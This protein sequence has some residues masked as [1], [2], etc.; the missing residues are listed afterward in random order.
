MP[1]IDYQCSQCGY[2]FEHF[3]HSDPPNSQICP[4]LLED[5]R[6]C[7]SASLRI[8]SLPGEYRPTNAQRF[9]PI[10]IWV[11]NDNPDQVS[12]PGRADEPVQA[13]YHPVEITSI[14]E[15]DRWTRKINASQVA[16]TEFHRECQKQYWDDVARQRR[17]DTRARIGNNPRAQELFRRVQQYVDLKRE[18]KYSKK[19]DARGHFQALSFDASNR[20]GYS[21]VETGWKERK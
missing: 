4:R 21:S 8:D 16:Q 17:D 18:R 11:N 14:Y 6:T 3:Y 13:G 12:F 19:L 10:V 1:M 15:A 9:S 2:R 5:G 20:Q 7:A